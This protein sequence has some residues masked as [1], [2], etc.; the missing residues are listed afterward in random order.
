MRRWKNQE[1]GLKDPIKMDGAHLHVL[2]DIRDELQAINTKLACYRI[3]PALDALMELGK[4]L[5]RRK[6]ARR[7]QRRK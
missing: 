6:R 2:M 3:P 5:R 4:D 7:K 1:W